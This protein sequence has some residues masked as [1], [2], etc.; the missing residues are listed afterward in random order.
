MYHVFMRIEDAR[1]ELDVLTIELKQFIK[2]RLKKGRDYSYYYD[3]ERNEHSLSMH[4]LWGMFILS[5]RDKQDDLFKMTAEVDWEPLDQ[6]KLDRNINKFIET[7]NLPARP[8]NLEDKYNWMLATSLRAKNYTGN[9]GRAVVINPELLNYTEESNAFANIFSAIEDDYIDIPMPSNNWFTQS[10]DKII[11]RVWSPKFDRPEA[12][13]PQAQKHRRS[14]MHIDFHLKT[15]HTFVYPDDSSQLRHVAANIIKDW[16]Q[17]KKL[18]DGGAEIVERICERLVILSGSEEVRRISAIG[19]LYPMYNEDI[20]IRRENQVTTLLAM[21][22]EIY[23]NKYN[24]LSVMLDKVVND[25]RYIYLPHELFE[26]YKRLV[27]KP[28]FKRILGLPASMTK[29]WVSQK[30][31]T[32]GNVHVNWSLR[33]YGSYDVLE[34]VT[35]GSKISTSVVKVNNI[36]R[37]SLR[38]RDVYRF[39]HDRPVIEVRITED[40][41]RVLKQVAKT[42]YEATS[43]RASIHFNAIARASFF[44][45]EAVRN[46]IRF[47]KEQNKNVTARMARLEHMFLFASTNRKYKYI[48]DIDEFE[49]GEGIMPMIIVDEELEMQRRMFNNSTPKLLSLY[50]YLINS[51]IIGGSEIERILMEDGE[52]LCFLGAI[53]EPAREIINELHKASDR[54]VRIIGYGDEA[55]APNVRV[56]V[57]INNLKNISA[58][59]VISDINQSEELLEFEE[60]V[61]F[62]LTILKQCLKISRN[63]A[64][65]LNHPSVYLI[66]KMCEYIYDNVSTRVYTSLVKVATQNPFT[67]EAFFV[68]KLVEIDKEEKFFNVRETVISKNYET[69]VGDERRAYMPGVVNSVARDEID[70]LYVDLVSMQVGKDKLLDTMSRL[71]QYMSE[72]STYKVKEDSE[73]YALFGRMSGERILLTSRGVRS[74]TDLTNVIRAIPSGM[75]RNDGRIIDLPRYIQVEWTL[76]HKQACYYKTRDYLMQNDLYVNKQKVISVGGRNLTD[77]RM[78]PNECEYVIYDPHGQDVEL[79][80]KDVMIYQDEFPI[81]EAREYEE[82]S[83]YI[84]MFVI[85]NEPD[86][87]ASTKDEQMDK[88]RAMAEAVRNRE[89]TVCVFNVYTNVTLDAFEK[90]NIVDGV[91]L[92]DNAMT[93]GDHEP[94]TVLDNDEILNMIAEEGVRGRIIYP[95]LDDVSSGQMSEA[96]IV[97]G[98]RNIHLMTAL[99]SMPI[100][101]IY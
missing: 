21:F 59:Y 49:T 78:V 3:V 82:A 100:F 61:E 16:R 91:T 19:N 62:S 93:F 84:F 41:W 63:G 43:S 23:K 7:V 55:V 15:P 32:E 56:T 48:D 68:Y 95:S 30:I 64:I 37:S 88:I 5:D 45:E 51:V 52:S 90:S 66:N 38:L 101:V 9:D 92:R 70:S 80:H 72:V 58:T 8:T 71:S 2:K 53:S 94:S 46:E 97:K 76:L 27:N 14:C 79:G 69:N 28:F 73:I 13:I 36:G 31:K 40:E 34:G 65:K 17:E 50:Y 20:S 4:G 6:K 96:I 98:L 54:N 29:D 10:D 42:R 87:S 47:L 11:V 39:K 22:N 89:N 67:N 77:I 85:M 60:M 81:S 74:S 57:P 24:D 1:A 18:R 99:N 44:F 83:I 26:A 75:G 35:S 86:G 33:P 12:L 25:E